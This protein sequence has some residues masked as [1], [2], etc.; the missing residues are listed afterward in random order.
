M[1]KEIDLMKVKKITLVER[2]IMIK[3]IEILCQVWVYKILIIL[4]KLIKLKIKIIFMAM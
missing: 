2:N 4:K 3:L 1:N